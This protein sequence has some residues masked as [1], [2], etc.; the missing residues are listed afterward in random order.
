MKTLH[1]RAS[2]EEDVALAAALLQSGQLVAIPTE[3][4]YGLA[5]RLGDENAIRTIF[6][7]K[8][9]PPDNPLIVHC[10]RIDDISQVATRIP[11]IAWQLLE[12]FA[13]GPLTLVLERKEGVPAIISAGLPTVAVRIPALDVTREVIARVG[14]PVVAPSANRSGRPSPTCVAHV[15]EDLD[16]MIAA[17]LDA[18]PCTIGIESTVLN[19]VGDIAIARPG[20]ITA[21]DLASVLG[22]PPPLMDVSSHTPIAPGMK[23]RHY[24][25]SI[26][27]ILIE[28]LDA[29]P[30]VMQNT[31]V[32]LSTQPLPET[33]NWRPLH[34]AT[35][36]DEF[37]RAERQQRQAIYVLLTPDV[38][39]DVALMNRLQKAA[40]PSATSDVSHR[41]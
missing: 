12:R 20:A 40:A 10:A 13:P 8:G 11:P 33:Y 41:V 23:Y 17:V 5:A 24:A 1:L 4:V 16:G 27:V 25:P 6:Q 36:Y 39:K 19:L 29:L 9:R 21:E 35:V 2:S 32:V 22:F 28:S 15:L 26:P 30:S 38:R 14:E 31:S 18:G 34:R 37:R 7:V 3:T